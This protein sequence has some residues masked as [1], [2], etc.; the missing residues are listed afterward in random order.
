MAKKPNP[1]IESYKGVNI[2]QVNEVKLSL[3]PIYFKRIIDEVD[4]TG[5]SIHKVLAYSGKPCE[6]CKDI[7]VTI[8]NEEG[9]P[10]NIRRGILHVPEGNGISILEKAKIRNKTC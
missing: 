7:G 6:R 8:Y 1:I 4:K 3:N 9:E 10:I 5:L 2:R